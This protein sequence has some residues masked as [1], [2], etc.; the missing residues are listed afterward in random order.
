LIATFGLSDM[1]HCTSKVRRRNLSA[2][3]QADGGWST[4]VFPP[5]HPRTRF[6]DAGKLTVTLMFIMPMH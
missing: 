6:V 4:R 2:D 5:R 1:G 3:A